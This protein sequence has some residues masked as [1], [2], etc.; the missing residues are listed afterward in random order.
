MLNKMKSSGNFNQ[1]FS[2]LQLLHSPF[3]SCKINAEDA[4]VA[5]GWLNNS[6]HTGLA[7]WKPFS[8][9]ITYCYK[10]K[11]EFPHN[12]SSIKN[13]ELIS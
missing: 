2:S 3:K 1:C 13:N 10:F 5:M 12:I 8:R 6:P 9:N 7:S 11:K 4:T